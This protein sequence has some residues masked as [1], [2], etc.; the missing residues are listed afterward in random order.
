MK[1]CCLTEYPAKLKKNLNVSIMNVFPSVKY[2]VLNVDII[3]WVGRQCVKV[4]LT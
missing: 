2:K 4:K 1:L 3:I